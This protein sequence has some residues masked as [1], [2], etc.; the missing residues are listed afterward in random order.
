MSDAPVKIAMRPSHPGAFIRA[1]VLDELGLSV[2]KAADVLG[3]RRATLSDLVNEKAALSPEMAL[4]IEKAFGV[5][6]DTL[7]RMQAWF[8][9]VAMREQADRIDV[10]RYAPGGSGG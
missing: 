1:E 8:D 3:V 6:M 7:L 4:R 9:A 5:S 10:Q 2:S